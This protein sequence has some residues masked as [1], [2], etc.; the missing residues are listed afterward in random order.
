MARLV[1]ILCIFLFLSPCACTSRSQS[2]LAKALT[3]AVKDK[4]L[5]KGKMENILREY[6]ML[7]ENEPE[8]AREYATQIVN[9]IEM[10]ADSSHIEVLRRQLR[11][12][13]KKV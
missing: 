1:S 9:A 2:K 4:K 7:R 5:S 12:A 3:V 10:G 6:E 13:L 8:K 11:G